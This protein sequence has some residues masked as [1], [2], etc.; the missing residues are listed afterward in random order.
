MLRNCPISKADIAAAEDIFGP[1]LGWLKGKTVRRNNDHVPSLVANVP[2]DIIKLYKDVS[3]SF[4]IMFV[5][6]IA[7]VVTVSQHIRFGTTERIGSRQADVVAKAVVRVITF[8]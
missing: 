6:K 2:Y 8:Y 5:N 7:F 3:L 4:D 1:N